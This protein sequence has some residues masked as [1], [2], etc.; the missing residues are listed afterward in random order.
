[1]TLEGLR[2]FCAVVE[3]KSFRG[4]A[5][6]V[7]RSQPAVSQQVKA[8]EEEFG[9]VLIERKSGR[10]TPIG[11][12]LYTRARR[13]LNDSASLTRELGEFDEAKGGELRVGSSDTTALYFL[14]PMVREFARR[15]PLTTLV[16][17]NRPS[18]AIAEGIVRGE[19]D[20]G[21]VTLP[22]L[23]DELEEQEL[24]QERLVLVTPRS[25]RLG[26]RR[27]VRLADLRDERFLLLDASTRTGTLLRE[28]F[29]AEG[30]EPRVVLDSGS[31]E[32]IKRY[33]AEGVGVSFLPEIAVGPADEAL[34][35][36]ETVGLPS[37]R[38]G[39]TWRRGAY[40]GGAEK[41]FL[42][43]IAGRGK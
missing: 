6:R 11:Q 35:T 2:C 28:H 22:L 3:A 40:Q 43:V 19:L 39:V 26:G 23:R 29:E 34:A 15:M 42:D 41:T 17:V 14:P 4:A 7:H 38:I 8:L 16:M 10:P 24:F 31:F 13:I 27:R 36:V 1:M 12:V 30:F 25:H 5:A 9:R 37:V 32:V 21:I 33:V 20:L 18:N